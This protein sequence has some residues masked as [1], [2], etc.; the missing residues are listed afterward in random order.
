MANAEYLFVY[1]LLRSDIGGPMQ[2]RLAEAARL[3]GS[4]VCVVAGPSVPCGGV[5]R[6]SAVR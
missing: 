5:P 2:S 3:V 4:A 6:C 1:G